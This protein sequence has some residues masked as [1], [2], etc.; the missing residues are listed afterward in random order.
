MGQWRGTGSAWAKDGN[1]I[2]ALRMIAGNAVMAFDL[3]AG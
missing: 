2:N 3:S 1:K